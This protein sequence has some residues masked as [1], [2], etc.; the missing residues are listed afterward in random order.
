[1]T[2]PMGFKAKV[3]LSSPVLFLSIAYN[4][5]QILLKRMLNHVDPAH[6]RFFF[7]SH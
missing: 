3:D 6:N 2:L 5:P 7:F 1:M 4:D